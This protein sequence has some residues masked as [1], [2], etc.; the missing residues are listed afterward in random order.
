M[1]YNDNSLYLLIA[2]PFITFFLAIGLVAWVFKYL[3]A[4]RNTP[5]KTKDTDR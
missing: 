1:N 5:A 3:M 2:L 4:A